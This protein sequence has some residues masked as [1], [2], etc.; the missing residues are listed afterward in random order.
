VTLE[1]VASFHFLFSY[2]DGLLFQ[3]IRSL[4]T[5]SSQPFFSVSSFRS[6]LGFGGNSKGFSGSIRKAPAWGG[7]GEVQHSAFKHW[8]PL[9][10]GIVEGLGGMQ[11]SVMNP[12]VYIHSPVCGWVPHC[13]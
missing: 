12:A 13:Q 3:S 1:V 11:V 10:L 5:F 4:K 9:D 8:L 7:D 2:A 6:P